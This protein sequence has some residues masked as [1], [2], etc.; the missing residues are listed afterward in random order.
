MSQGD[1]E[2]V[3]TFE[4]SIV[5]ANYAYAKS[6]GIS[7]DDILLMEKEYA[8]LDA[9]LSRP[10]D[11]ENPVLKIENIEFRLQELWKFGKD[12][13][14]HSYWMQIDGC[15][16]PIEDNLERFGAGYRVYSNSCKW[17]GESK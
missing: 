3:L 10:D 6:R 5:H 8:E 7:D 13:D 12:K 1:N 2:Y 9:L 11:F 17:H 16:C 4:D 15:T 14:K